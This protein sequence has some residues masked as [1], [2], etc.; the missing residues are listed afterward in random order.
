MEERWEDFKNAIIVSDDHYVM[1][2][3]LRP[4][5]LDH[6][7]WLEVIGSPLLTQEENVT[8]LD[9]ELASLIC[10][11]GYM[12]SRNIPYRKPS[13]FEQ[14]RFGFRA[15]GKNRIFKELA[16]FN[17]YLRDFSS[18][19]EI[20]S[21]SEG[22]KRSMFP[23]V[24]SISAH[25]VKNHLYNGDEEAIWTMPLGKAH[26]Y[27]VAFMRL[28]GED[29]KILTEHDREFIEGLKRNKLKSELEE[30]LGVSF[31]EEEQNAE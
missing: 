19:P 20:G 28:E 13:F 22:E 12:E 30:K 25:L 27:S 17:R 9:L 14:L 11:S 18:I 23:P 10:C 29:V 2:R 6:Q 7:F 1:G 24:A 5:C 21:K 16:A 3:K 31:G 26:W 8:L 15:I 4:F